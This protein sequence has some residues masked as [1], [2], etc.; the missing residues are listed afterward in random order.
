MGTYI[1]QIYTAVYI[2]TYVTVKISSF[3]Q[4]SRRYVWFN[5]EE[6]KLKGKRKKEKDGANFGWDD[7]EK[8]FLP[9]TTIIFFGVGWATVERGDGEGGLQH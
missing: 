1:Q 7:I 9:K 2:Y 3:C 5:Y 4:A 8:S 6:K